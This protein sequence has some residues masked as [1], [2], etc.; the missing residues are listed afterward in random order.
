ML[1]VK[2]QVILYIVYA[3]VFDTLLSKT[4]SLLLSEFHTSFVHR[5][6]VCIYHESLK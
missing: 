5:L 4:I 6:V 3:V 2:Y 1:S